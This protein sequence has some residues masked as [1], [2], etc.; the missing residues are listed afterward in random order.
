MGL[1]PGSSG[2]STRSSQLTPDLLLQH[3][4][5][6]VE[7]EAICPVRG[8]L[9]SKVEVVKGRGSVFWVVPGVCVRGWG[10]VGSQAVSKL[11]S[12]VDIRSKLN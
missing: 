6:P 11:G 3:L 4:R 5:E 2:C 7:V 12:S 1:L 10:G 9:G 8:C